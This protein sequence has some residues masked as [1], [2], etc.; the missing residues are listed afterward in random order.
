MQ[1]LTKN[2]LAIGLMLLLTSSLQ[3]QP[4]SVYP[5]D[6]NNN[7]ECNHVDLLYIGLGYGETGQGRNTVG[8]TWG[9]QVT[10]TPWSNTFPNG[11][12]MVYGDC[13]GDSTIDALDVNAIDLN[14]LQTHGTIVP[15]T[16]PTAN[17]TDPPIVFNIS[18]DSV[19][20]GDTLT[21]PIMVGAPINPVD[22][23][24]GVAVTIDFNP[25]LIDTIYMQYG[26]SAFAILGTAPLVVEKL[27]KANGKLRV[28][29]CRFDHV[30]VAGT[31]TVGDIVIVMDDNLKTKSTIE[32]MFKLS[33]GEVMAIDASGNKFGLYPVAD[34]VGVIANINLTQDDLT[35]FPNPANDVIKIQ[36]GRELIQDFMIMDLQ[37]RE[38]LS[39]N[40]L[41]TREAS[42][43]LN[44]LV[45]GTY[46][47][48][49]KTTGGRSY[50]R[51][52]I[53]H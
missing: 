26:S 20:A 53:R 23:I 25:A 30:N 29:I 5:G 52:L 10:Q 3:A 42:I 36:S 19:P 14:F 18:P 21:V 8:I 12:N 43:N 40:D 17:P 24:Y 1:L 4:F 37:G 9:P 38:Q 33:F 28:G 6:A 2:L 15:D 48:R 46:F 51:K 49:M 34:S 47:I 11:L 44:S 32:D 13:N 41:N 35:V 7:G 16:F 45:P 31:G 50:M 22:S 39:E 27:D